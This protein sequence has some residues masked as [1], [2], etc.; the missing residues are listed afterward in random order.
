MTGLE[1]T[2]ENVLQGSL[3]EGD[4]G[5]GGGGG[6][7]LIDRL[8]HLNYSLESLRSIQKFTYGKSWCDTSEVSPESGER[9]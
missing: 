4:K 5:L 2:K 6:D 3:D 7:K 9:V 8:R 1:V